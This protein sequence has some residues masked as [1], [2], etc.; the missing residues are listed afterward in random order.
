MLL[1]LEDDAVVYANAFKDPIPIEQSVI[2]YGDRCTRL[3]APFSVYIDDWFFGY[4]S[5]LNLELNG[6]AYKIVKPDNCMRFFICRKIDKVQC[7][8]SLVWAGSSAWLEDVERLAGTLPLHGKGRR[9]KSGLTIVGM[10]PRQVDWGKSGPAHHIILRR[11]PPNLTVC[12]I[13]IQPRANIDSYY[14]S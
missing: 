7:S 8:Q 11:V 3:G 14:K 1:V 13:G 4:Q 6:L 10:N 5:Q 9:F 2:E 12:L